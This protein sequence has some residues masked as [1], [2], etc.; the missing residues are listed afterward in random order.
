M[1][2]VSM[3]YGRKTCCSHLIREAHIAVPLDKVFHGRETIG[4]E[5]VEDGPQL[6]DVVL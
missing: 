5:Q 6:G 3:R 2:Y 1:R 4:V